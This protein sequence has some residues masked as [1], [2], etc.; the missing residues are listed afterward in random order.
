VL[1]KRNQ[2]TKIKKKKKKELKVKKKRQLGNFQ[3][4]RERHA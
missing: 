1:K 4:R 3:M 2:P